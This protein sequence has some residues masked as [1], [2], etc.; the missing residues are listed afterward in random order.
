MAKGDKCWQR[1]KREGEPRTLRMS[2]SVMA[3]RRVGAA[4]TES[5]KAETT[6]ATVN[7]IVALGEMGGVKGG[8][9]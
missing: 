5:A 9:E 1:Y 3:A 4:L 2:V 7:F 8:E 6:A